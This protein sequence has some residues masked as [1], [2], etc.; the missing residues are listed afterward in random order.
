MLCEAMEWNHLPEAGGL[1]QQHP[2]LLDEWMTIFHMRADHDER[3][4]K[5]KERQAQKGPAR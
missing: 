2:Q 4:R 3:D 1:Y 5:N